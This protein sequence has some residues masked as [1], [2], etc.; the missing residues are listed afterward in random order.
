MI[1]GKY[2]SGVDSIVD[3]RK[4]I[5]YC[6]LRTTF[7]NYSRE[8]MNNLISWENEIF[9]VINT[10]GKPLFQLYEIENLKTRKGTVVHSMAV[11]DRCPFLS[12]FDSDNTKLLS[13]IPVDRMINVCEKIPVMYFPTTEYLNDIIAKTQSSLKKLLNMTKEEENNN[14]GTFLIVESLNEIRQ[15]FFDMEFLSIYYGYFARIFKALYTEVRDDVKLEKSLKNNIM[16]ALSA[17]WVIADTFAE[18]LHSVLVKKFYPMYNNIMIPLLKMYIIPEITTMCPNWFDDNQY[19][20]NN[21]ENHLAIHIDCSKN[22]LEDRYQIWVESNE[23]PRTI[24]RLKTIREVVSINS[25]KVYRKYIYDILSKILMSQGIFKD[26]I[27]K[28]IK[29]Y[30]NVDKSS[31]LPV[32]SKELNYIYDI[33]VLEEAIGRIKE[34]KLSSEY[35]LNPSREFNSILRLHNFDL[36]L[37][38]EDYVIT[39]PIEGLR[40]RWWTDRVIILSVKEPQLI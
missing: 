23:P 35:P 4:D 37:T 12:K 39:Y 24:K 27:S 20:K 28:M 15:T 14:D 29:N 19:L 18:D 33:I 22:K 2:L 36:F 9:G 32:A 26:E 31:Q 11:L 16:K 25:G 8:E 6:N 3:V 13:G 1:N 34:L 10:T 7:Y 21:A 30:N 17:L 38:K 40:M 5:V